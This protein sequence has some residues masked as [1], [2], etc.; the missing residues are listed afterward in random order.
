M[1]GG[2]ERRGNEVDIIGM[3]DSKKVTAAAAACTGGKGRQK[4][5]EIQRENKRRIGK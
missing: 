5:R 4:Q 3:I 2:E 1:T